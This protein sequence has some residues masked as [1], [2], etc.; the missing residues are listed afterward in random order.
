MSGFGK[1]KEDLA[2]KVKFSSLLT[3]KKIIDKEYEHVPQVWNKLQ[4]NMMKDYHSLL[5]KCNVL[6]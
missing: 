2:N 4:M 5:L 1:F 3:G 6:K